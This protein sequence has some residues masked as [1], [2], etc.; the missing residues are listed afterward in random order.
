[1]NLNE[2]FLI[3][4]I[5]LLDIII[6][7]TYFTHSRIHKPHTKF[8]LLSLVLYLS[9]LGIYLPLDFLKIVSIPYFYLAITVLFIPCL[10]IGIIINLKK[11][12]EIRER[13]TNS[14]YGCLGFLIFSVI[15]ITLAVTVFDPVES[16]YGSNVALGCFLLFMAIWSL[17]R[18]FTSERFSWLKESAFSVLFILLSVLSFFDYFNNWSIGTVIGIGVA[19]YLIGRKIEKRYDNETYI[20]RKY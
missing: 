9:S 8:G 20:Y 15:A 19:I 13:F 7:Y 4:L 6:L 1:M 10:L 2:Y 11:D 3:A 5:L 12:I 17:I 18:I 14:L 16:R